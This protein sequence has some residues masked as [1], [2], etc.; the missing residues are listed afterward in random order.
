[1]DYPDHLPP[2]LTVY[3]HL[4]T[5]TD[6]E[7]AAASA[8]ERERIAKWDLCDICAAARIH[9]G[10]ASTTAMASL[11]GV[12]PQTVRRYQKAGVIF[13]PDTR[14]AEA[15]MS[16]YYTAADYAEDPIAAVHHALDDGWSARQLREWLKGGGECGEDVALTDWRELLHV[17]EKCP[18]ADLPRLLKAV[19]ETVIGLEDVGQALEVRLKFD[20]TGLFP[21]AKEAKVA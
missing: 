2:H 16:L 12:V 13:P 10:K 6:A 11:I 7:S 5:L 3:A 19:L 18:A 15:A 20:L 14:Y 9:V 17:D 8:V 4:Q 21:V 1:M